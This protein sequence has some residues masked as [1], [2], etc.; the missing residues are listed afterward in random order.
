MSIFL[1]WKWTLL[2]NMYNSHVMFSKGVQTQKITYYM[3]L[4]I[5]KI[6]KTIVLAVAC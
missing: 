5:Y 6:Q 4:Y 1:E 3:N 2:Q